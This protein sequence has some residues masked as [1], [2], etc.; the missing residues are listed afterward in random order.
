MTLIQAVRASRLHRLTDLAIARHRL[1][2]RGDAVLIGVSGGAD[3]VALLHLL[4]ARAPKH[5]LRLGVAHLNHRL[6]KDSGRDAD[7]VRDL[8]SFF[9]LTFYGQQTDVRGVQRRFRLSLEEAARS[10]RYRFFRETAA[11]HGYNKV[12]LG[13]HADDDAE[14]LMLNLLRGSGRLGLGGIPPI[15]ER[16][17][18]RP[19]IHAARSDIMEYLQILGL[20]YLSDCTNTDDRYLRNRIRRRLIPILESDYHAEV[21]AVFSRTAEILRAEEQWLESLMEPILRQVITSRGDEM[22]VLSAHELS[23]IHR[24]AARRAARGALRLFQGDLRRITFKHIEQIVDFACRRSDAGPLCLPRD[25]QVCRKGDHLLLT[26]T[27]AGRTFKEP[28]ALSDDFQYEL[29]GCGVLA[30]RETGETVAVSETSRDAAEGF[31][32]SDARMALLDMDSIEFPITIRNFRAG[33]RFFP[34]GAGGCQKLKKFFIDHKIPRDQRR[35]CP[36]LLSRGRI[37]WVA[38]HRID[39][40]VRLTQATRRVLRAV[41]IR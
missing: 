16:F 6:R 23:R 13:H 17:F 39:Q 1:L 29:N 33:D 9:G 7:F 41:L 19:M 18:I 31:M 40:R 10:A 22:L 5:R 27:Q 3:S 28:A 15:R 24:A 26:R 35:R 30:I 34:L 2:A 25:I 37:V 14:T 11:S 20:T 8:A 4:M 12:A 32:T 21:R 38:G 36:L